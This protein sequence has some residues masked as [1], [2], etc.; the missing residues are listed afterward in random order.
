MVDATTTLIRR[1]LRGERFYQAHRHHAFQYAARKHRSHK[2]VSLSVLAI[3]TL[4]LLP[5]AVA[6][7]LQWLD[8]SV[9]VA[10]AYSPL[11]WLA[12]R[13]KAGDREAQGVLA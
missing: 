4:W 10:L 1:V 2:A 5:V 3:N 9:G 13:Y 6:V 12:F 8:G 11:L 7:A